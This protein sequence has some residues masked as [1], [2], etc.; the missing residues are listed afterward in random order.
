MQ[1][2]GG[3]SIGKALAGLGQDL[4]AGVEKYQE[5]KKI[6]AEM[7]GNVEGVISAYPE[8]VA[9]APASIAPLLK[10]LVDNGT[11]N[12]REA[13]TLHGYVAGQ[14]NALE[15]KIKQD[16]AAAQAAE[17]RARA[18]QLQ[19]LAATQENA[20]KRPQAI[21]QTPDEAYNVAGLSPDTGK[22]EWKN[23]RY[24]AVP[25]T[26]KERADLD[27]MENEKQQAIVKGDTEKVSLI[28]RGKAAVEEI[29][30]T[31]SL[32][33]QA[34]SLAEA[35]TGG[36]VAGIAPVRT[37]GAMATAIPLAG[38]LFRAAG[39]DFAV[40]QKSLYDTIRARL[41]FD[42]IGE[43][44][45]LSESGSTGLGAISNL[46]FTALG[47]SAGQ[48]AVN[49]PEDMQLAYLKTMRKTLERLARRKGSPAGGDS[50]SSGQIE[51]SSEV[52]A[53]LQQL[54]L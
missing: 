38:N 47:D 10:K 42:K 31:I 25:L 29:T 49:L 21:P 19:G 3:E 32:I 22:V 8:V 6:T 36:P 37:L 51:I 9:N 12:Q 30:D 5:N 2:R 45:S 43:I 7:L 4:A 17:A 40:R 27:K 20:R 13:M 14:K 11:V 48:V 16:L 24:I 53:A 41:T 50:G 1:A 23:D 34:I 35:G 15:A 54:G 39:S 46:E 52:D 18:Q 26:P 28:N 33:D 44:K